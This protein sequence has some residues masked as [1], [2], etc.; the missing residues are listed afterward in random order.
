MNKYEEKLK[1]FM[2]DNAINGEH[3]VFDKPCRSVEEAAEAIQ[4]SPGDFIK[5]ICMVD[6]QDQMIV[7]IVKGEDRASTSR[8]AKALNIERPRIATP[9]EVLKKGYPVGGVPPF[10][11]EAVFLIDPHVME[12]DAVYG[13]GGSEHSLVKIAPE[14]LR[15]ANN[16]RIV[17]VRK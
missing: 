6:T 11:F 13:G 17:R 7:A 14:E 5:S 1:A 3:L 8:V 4:G 16:G 12:Q 15:K 2:R 9:E 10:G